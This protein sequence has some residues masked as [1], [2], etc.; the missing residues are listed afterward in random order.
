MYGFYRI[1]KE[2][3]DFF[4][5]KRIINSGHFEKAEILGNNA[6]LFS[7]N[8]ETQKYPSLKWG[9][10]FFF[11][12]VGAIISGWLYYYYDLNDLKTYYVREMLLMGVMLTSISLGFLVYFFVVMKS[13]KK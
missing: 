4:L 7:E 13:K 6:A 3:L 9:L 11:T 12:G 1:I 8:T 5:K 2:F 10:V